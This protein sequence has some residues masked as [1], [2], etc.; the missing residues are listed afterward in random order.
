[1]RAACKCGFSSSGHEGPRQMCGPG[2][3]SELEGKLQGQPVTFPEPVMSD[4]TSVDFQ[5]R[6]GGLERLYGPSSLGQLTKQH[7]VVAG[8]GGVGSWCVEALARTGVG[9][10]SLI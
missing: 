8:I 2:R 3:A 4:A 1:E 7:V 6:F 9:A 10:I 5:R